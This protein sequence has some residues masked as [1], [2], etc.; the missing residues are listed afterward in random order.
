MSKAL[1]QKASTGQSTIGPKTGPV[2]NFPQLPED[3]PIFNAGYVIGIK[4]SDNSSPS[5]PATEEPSEPSRPASTLPQP[6]EQ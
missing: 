5:P 2:P 4:R 6:D 1:V 3:H